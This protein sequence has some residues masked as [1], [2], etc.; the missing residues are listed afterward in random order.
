MNSH[1]VLPIVFELFIKS[2]LIVIGAALLTR[3]WRA[4]TSAQRHLVWLVALV[5]ILLLP[6][7]RL[8]SPRWAVALHS[9]KPAPVA[10]SPVASSSVERIGLT[11][12]P[13]LQ[14]AALPI[15]TP[16]DWSRI[17]LALWLAGGALVLGYR[18][19]GSWQVSALLRHHTIVG[20]ESLAA[21]ARHAAAEMGLRGPRRVLL[22][23]GIRVPCT[24]GFW[25]PVV[26]L[27]TTALEWPEDR[28]LAALRH[29]FAHVVR[30]DYLARWVG[31]LAC[32]LYWPNPL[33]WLAARCMHLAQEQACDDLVLRAG[34]PATDYAALLVDV[35]CGAL[36]EKELRAAVAMARPSTLEGRVLAIVDPT[37]N[38]RPVGWRLSL[39]SV[40]CML[41]VVG[42]SALVQIAP[43]AAAEAPEP[44]PFATAKPAEPALISLKEGLASPV[45][46]LLPIRVENE[47]SDGAAEKRTLHI[48]IKAKPTTQIDM[49]QV[50][51]QVLFY[52]LV[53]GRDLQPT[54]ADVH[55]HWLTQPANW[56][57]RAT[58]E[59]AVDYSRPQS[60]AE[61]EP[62]RKYH[63][64]IVRLYY[65]GRLQG[66][67]SSPQDLLQEFPSQPPLP[68]QDGGRSSRKKADSPAAIAFVRAVVAMDR[69]EKQEE[70]G[71]PEG[72]IENMRSAL[73]S[74]DEVRKLDPEWEPKL[75]AL[76]RARAR[77]A[78]TRLAGKLSVAK[79][80]VIDDS[81]NHSPSRSS[82]RLAYATPGDAFVNAYMWV[83]KGERFQTE[84]DI[85]AA[86][87]EMEAAARLFDDISQ[88]TPEW[89]PDVVAYRKKRTAAA[90]ESLR[91]ALVP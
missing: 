16:V 11:A 4:S 24:W 87:R 88:A 77:K 18:L 81:A 60:L 91:A 74:L 85:P 48:S 32:A 64:Y 56:V 76:R 66:A 12:A 38:R 51:I 70:E 52:D 5:A 62:E 30:R 90:I 55:S 41:V 72:A 69:A 65:H 63:G 71:D 27:P 73:R 23:E 17:V 28:L 75:V 80:E 35:A 3:G 26:L 37:R 34:T 49:S 44:N 22:A 43:Q 45:L 36:I 46:Q 6:L 42:A 84:G 89:Q 19:F 61:K 8:A 9:A 29:E 31:L 7:T 13:G 54:H 20:N 1:T 86:L 68:G 47:T 2:A 53:D 58:E 40:L 83:K 67:A 50:T 78:I 25:R 79:A 82:S 14:S 15:S 10:I 21:L 33:V 57:E 59:L 39:A